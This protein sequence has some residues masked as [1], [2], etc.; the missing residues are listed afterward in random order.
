MIKKFSAVFD[1][2]R[3]YNFPI[4]LTAMLAGLFS[5]PNPPPVRVAVG[6]FW[7]FLGCLGCQAWNDYQDVEVDCVNAPH[8]PIPSGRLS[9]KEVHRLIHF[10]LLAGLIT[11]LIYSWICIPLILAAYGLTKIY[12]S[13]KRVTVFNHVLMPLSESLAPI[14]GSLLAFGRVMPAAWFSVFLIFF[15]DLNMNII[16]SFKD[17][18]DDSIK[19][20]VLPVV[21]GPKFAALFSL[22]CGILALS[23]GVVPIVLGLV[24]QWSLL[25]LGIA[26]FLTIKSRLMVLNRFD[27]K[28]GYQALKEG[29]LAEVTSYPSLICGIIS[30]PAALF[31]ITAILLFT[32]YSQNI[33][34]ENVYAQ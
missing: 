22:F 12:P 2:M 19:E 30:L 1:L 29:R 16:G 3:I 14:C 23:I 34:P 8:R 32:F 21:A 20:K 27:A 13:L 28:T 26:A 33:I 31:L 6:I 15:M 18:Q 4:P 9:K 10:I 17:L 7:A 24:S 11:A 5:A 25:F